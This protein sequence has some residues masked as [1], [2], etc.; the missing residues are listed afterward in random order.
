MF[1]IMK[2]IGVEE[3]I[4]I[5]MELLGL[6]LWAY[7]F[8]IKD[9]AVTQSVINQGIMYQWFGIISYISFK[10]L[11]MIQDILEIALSMA[12][13]IKYLS[14]IRDKD[15]QDLQAIKSIVEE[16]KDKE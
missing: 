12:Y 6:F 10:I 11:G 3:V 4:L 9:N 15:H 14:S 2:K 8:F 13:N 5:G 1:N 16:L 7:S